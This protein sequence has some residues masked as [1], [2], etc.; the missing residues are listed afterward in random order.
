MWNHNPPDL[1]YEVATREQSLEAAT[2]ILDRL[3][4]TSTARFPV[5]DEGPCED[6]CG[7]KGIRVR[8]GRFSVCRTCALYRQRAGE[9]IE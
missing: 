2:L 4:G 9:K 3:Y 1:N 8:F 5:V 6:L 7:R